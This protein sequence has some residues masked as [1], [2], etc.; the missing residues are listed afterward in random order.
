MLS[1]ALLVA[2]GG[3]KTEDTPTPEPAPVA[4]ATEIVATVST[5]APA[6]ET[7]KVTV[8]FVVSDVEQSLYQD[9]SRCF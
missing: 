8:R 6:A 2:C 1:S 3:K 7:E 5:P 9:L 4:T